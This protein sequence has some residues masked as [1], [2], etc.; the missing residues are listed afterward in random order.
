MHMCICAKHVCTYIC[1]CACNLAKHQQL[2][3][4]R[5]RHRYMAAAGGSDSVCH[6]QPR[7]GQL[8]LLA[9]SVRLLHSVHLHF[10]RR[11]AQTMHPN[12]LRLLFLL[13]LLQPQVASC[14]LHAA[15]V[16][17]TARFGL[18]ATTDSPK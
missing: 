4:C 18:Q 13:K 17:A 12:G 3:H 7:L 8:G 2:Q 9:E 16:I 6:P 10:P 11:S 1:M 15:F 5:H 14:K